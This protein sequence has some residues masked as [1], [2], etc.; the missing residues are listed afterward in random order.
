MQRLPDTQAVLKS[1]TW[2][3]LETDGTFCFELAKGRFS[4]LG[5]AGTGFWSVRGGIIPHQNEGD[6]PDGPDRSTL[7]RIIRDQHQHLDGHDLLHA[8]HYLTDKEG[9]KL[10]AKLIPFLDLSHLADNKRPVLV[11]E[12]EGGV[13]D[14]DS[15]YTWRNLP[16][17]SPAALLMNFPLTVYQLIVH[18][19]GLTKASDGKPDGRVKLCIHLLGPEQELNFLPL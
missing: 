7:S 16:K 14:W 13:K 10:P 5:S 2:G 3:R 15:W 6:D 1:F 19:L 11:T 12:F 17:R 4:V 9:W 8:K 18:T